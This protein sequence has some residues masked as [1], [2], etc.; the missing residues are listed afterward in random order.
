MSNLEHSL[1]TNEQYLEKN[2]SHVL[3]VTNQLLRTGDIPVRVYAHKEMNEQKNL[4]HKEQVLKALE[5]AYSNWTGF[6]RESEG[7]ENLPRF[8]FIYEDQNPPLRQASY[9]TVL[10][11]KTLDNGETLGRMNVRQDPLGAQMDVQT[12]FKV[13]DLFGSKL[14]RLPFE[15]LR[16][17]ITHELGHFF[18]LDHSEADK[19]EKREYNLMTAIH[20]NNTFKPSSTELDVLLDFRKRV[21]ALKNRAINAGGKPY[22][23]IDQ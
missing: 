11:V 9:M 4:K 1:K 23:R 20:T 2:P 12:H 15:S 3:E 8:K 10:F 5:E 7:G 19:N 17:V 6:L 14:T 13:R 22:I 18:G 16:S 21:L